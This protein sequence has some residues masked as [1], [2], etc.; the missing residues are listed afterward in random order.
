MVINQHFLQ[1]GTPDWYT[2]ERKANDLQVVGNKPANRV[3]TADAGEYL[4]RNK[5]GTAKDWFVQYNWLQFCY[6]HADSISI[7]LYV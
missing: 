5:T 4:E 7:I 2:T 1:L 6:G 3:H